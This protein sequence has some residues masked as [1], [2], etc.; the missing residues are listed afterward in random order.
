MDI[1][2][3]LK[4][5]EVLRLRPADIELIS[6]INLSISSFELMMNGNYDALAKE[7]DSIVV[8]EKVSEKT[9]LIA[10]SLKNLLSLNWASDELDAACNNML[11]EDDSELED[12]PVEETW[13]SKMYREKQ[14]DSKKMSCLSRKQ[15]RCSKTRQ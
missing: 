11:I 12:T 10:A 8:D 14:G 2:Y 15:R 7:L 9:R 5:V 13:E 4:L 6:S 3:K 1:K